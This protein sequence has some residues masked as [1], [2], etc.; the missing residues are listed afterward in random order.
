MLIMS[1]FGTNRGRI[2]TLSS[3]DLEIE[4]GKVNTTLSENKIILITVL[5]PIY[6]INV[7]TIYKVCRSS[8]EVVKIVIF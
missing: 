6:N 4:L 2:E 8:G 3:E 5:N 7:D 1:Q